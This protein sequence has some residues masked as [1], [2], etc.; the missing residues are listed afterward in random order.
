[1]GILGLA[2]LASLLL[3]TTMAQ[4]SYREHA[5]SIELSE[6]TRSIQESEAALERAASPRH[7]ARA[8]RRLGMVQAPDISFLSLEKGKVLGNPTAAK[9]ER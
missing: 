5:L 3:N 7:L 2:L 4:V 8:A 9:G 6:L 1:M